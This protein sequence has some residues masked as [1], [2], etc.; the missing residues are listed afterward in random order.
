MAVWDSI[1]ALRLGRRPNVPARDTKVYPALQQQSISVDQ[2]K[3]LAYKP[4]PRNLRWF[5]KNPYSRRAIN[6]IKNPIA[7]LEW[8]VAP[9]KGIEMTSELERQIEIAT[10]CIEHPNTDDTTRTMLEQVTE[11][12]LL[13]A[14]AIE[15]QI[16]ADPT[17]PLWLYPVDG[18]SIQIYPLWSGAPDEARYCQ[19]VGYGNFTGTASGERVD[20]RNDELMYIRPNPSTA[21]PFGLGP[22]EIAFTTIS[23]I[24]GVAEFAGN[25][26]TNSRPS[27]GIDLGDGATDGTLNAFRTY[28]RND[29]EGQGNMPIF[30]MTSTSAD[31]KTRGPNVLRFYPEGDDG[32]YL[33]YQE[34]LQRELAAAFDLSPQNL[35]IERDIN[36]NTSE[37]A[38]DRDR[39]QAIKPHAHALASHLTREAIIGRL[40]FTQLVFKF[41]GIEADDELNLAKVFE[42]EYRNNAMTPNEYR[43]LRGRKPLALPF[44]DLLSADLD[45]ATA[46]ARGTAIVDDEALNIHLERPPVPPKPAAKPKPKG[47]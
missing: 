24:L 42:T 46:A 41:K 22:L 37:V 13:G 20:L 6:A 38:E 21:T 23:R 29:V 40:G 11:D 12:L 7:M 34:F 43:E 39:K 8:E 26:A 5:A 19:I 15:M 45:I 18:L 47:K 32:L 4:N 1:K 14:G 30:A 17:R 9:K 36:R 44:A 27:I 25:V 31:G 33:A 28:W 16:G 3:K 10:F 2:R 35:G